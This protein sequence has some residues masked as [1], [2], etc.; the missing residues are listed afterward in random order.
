MSSA[1]FDREQEQLLRGVARQA[2]EHGL[3]HG[4]E[5]AV[6]VQDY[7]PL[8]RE[9][10]ATFVTLKVRDELRGCIG[11]LEAYRPL[12]L[13]VAANARAAAFSDP[14][15]DPLGR[16]QLASLQISI[17]ILSPAEAL[18][19]NDEA[20]LLAQLRPGIDGVVLSEGSQRGTFLPS[21]W[22][23]LP[24]RRDFLQQLKLKTGLPVD[25]WS[26]RIHAYR[27]TTHVIGEQ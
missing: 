5:L 21:V 12:V 4:R 1:E 14:R 10:R 23:S 3:G 7:P 15:F 6:D 16:E 22:E 27:Y 20:D 11:S 9:R 19:F 26:D 24:D 17:S 8:L 25:Y 13:D 18:H 2:I